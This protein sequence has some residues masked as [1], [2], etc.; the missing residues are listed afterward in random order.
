MR[1]GNAVSLVLGFALLAAGIGS[2]RAQTTY[3]YVSGNIIW[4]ETW[5]SGNAAF[6]LSAG[7]PCNGQYILNKSDPGFKNQYAMLVA[8]KLADRPVRVYIGNCIAS[9]GG[10]GS[11]AEVVYMYYD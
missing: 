1:R 9:E 11:Y 7:A 10:G 2:L 4:L 8:A 3:S 6:T 5:K